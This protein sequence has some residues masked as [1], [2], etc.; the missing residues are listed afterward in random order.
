MALPPTVSL[1][2][3]PTDI[4]IPCRIPSALPPSLSPPAAAK[5]TPKKAAQTCETK[6]VGRLFGHDVT[7]LKCEDAKPAPETTPARKAS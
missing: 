3:T 6:K 2:A 1:T 5:A 4:Q 7:H